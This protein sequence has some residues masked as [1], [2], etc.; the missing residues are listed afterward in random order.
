MKRTRREYLTMIHDYFKDLETTYENKDEI[1]SYCEDEIKKL[2]DRNTKRA[3]TLTAS[4]KENIEIIKKI[5]AL[6]SG[7][8]EPITA[9]EIGKELEISTNKAAALVRKI[10]G[11]EKEMIKGSGKSKVT[12]Y[13]LNK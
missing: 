1:M 3:T 9:F 11:V 5:E 2:D 10:E 13:K 6:L 12:G 4:Q 7:K 8:T